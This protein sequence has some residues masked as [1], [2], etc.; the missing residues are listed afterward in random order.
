MVRPT[1]LSSVR[2]KKTEWSLIKKMTMK[3]FS[4][5]ANA[6]RNLTAKGHKNLLKILSLGIG[7]AAGLVLI[8]KVCFEQTFD[9]FFYGSDRLYYLSMRGEVNSETRVFSVI[10]G[11]IMPLMKEYYP[12]IEDATRFT[13]I[14][15]ES[16]AVLE[17]NQRRINTGLVIVADSSMFRVLDRKCLAGDLNESLD[18][19]GQAVVCSSVAKKMASSLSSG[20]N[21]KADLSSIIGQK[22]IFAGYS[23]EAILTI[24]GVYEDYPLNSSHRPEVIISLK[25][26]GQF[27]WDGSQNL[28]GNER[29]RGFFRLT[30]GADVEAI[31]SSMPEFMEK[32]LPMDRIREAGFSMTFTAAPLTSYHTKDETQR[33]MTLILGLIAVA[34][35]L[36]S[37]LNYLLIV[38]STTAVRAK[39]MALR[40]CLGS[41]PSDIFLMMFAEALVHTVLATVIAGIAIFAFRTQIETILGVGVSSLFVGKP[42][43]ACVATI[44][45]LVIL[46]SIC[47][48]IFFNSVPIAAAFRNFKS[49]K[50]MWKLSLLAVEFI[51]VAFLG[52]MMCIITLQYH[53][54]TSA[55]LG[56]EYKNLAMV[57]LPEANDAQ[58]N[59]LIKD[60]RSL[61][62]V[63]DACFSYMSPFGLYSGDN[64]SIPGEVRQLFNIQD[65]YYVD[66]HYFNVFGLK[67]I[68]GSNFTPGL[69]ANKEMIVDRK[70][71]EMMKNTAGWDSVLDREVEVSA[72]RGPTRICGIIDGFHTGTF[73]N[74][75]EE[76]GKR[77]MGI[78]YCNPETYAGMFNFIFVKYD[79]L[80]PEAIRRTDNVIKSVLQD[81]AYNIKPCREIVRSCYEETINVRNSII[82]GGV[83]TLLIALVGLIGY[84]MDEVRRRSKEIA[85]RRINGAQFSQIRRMFL[86]DIM[87]IALPSTIAGCVLGKIA[88]YHWEQSFSIRAGEPLW[89][90]LATGLLTIGLIS[91]LS[92][93]YVQFTARK[94]PAESIKTE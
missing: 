72:H 79:V 82:A 37:V 52:S 93:L 31:N 84:I 68:E 14:T 73:A 13:T 86:R 56:F 6:T 81:Q 26:I 92:D 41:S 46:N 66:E 88:A 50:R 35:L 65:A 27:T 76:Y 62:G 85:V 2:T 83:V 61:S 44:A 5:I 3:F 43:A 4:N 53:K 30:K 90:F 45:I 18:V 16:T 49:S 8:S 58:K 23:S 36:T 28:V 33:N 9:D 20:K 21:G 55:D 25:S 10:P 38:L 24:A 19:E 71:V 22:F 17:E 34:L 40:K 94:N 77:P 11:G 60:I 15:N 51:A 12:Q 67:I 48:A 1:G 69:S 54:L 74:E 75:D 42:L 47:P 32:Y 78:F 89:V 63:E 7:L 59:Q 39:E 91:I 87:Y 57:S 80:D 64:I 70:F 29:Y